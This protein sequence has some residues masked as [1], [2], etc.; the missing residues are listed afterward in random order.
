MVIHLSFKTWGDSVPMQLK[1]KQSVNSLCT[2]FFIVMFFFF[3]LILV[4]IN[5]NLTGDNDPE[6]VTP[7]YS[8]CQVIKVF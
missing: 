1:F 6:M 2:Y 7:S 5:I 8:I 3:S 4:L